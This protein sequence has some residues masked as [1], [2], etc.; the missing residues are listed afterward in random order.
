MLQV[1]QAYYHPAEKLRTHLRFRQ[2]L[3]G[4][5][6]QIAR[7]AKTLNSAGVGLSFSCF[8]PVFFSTRRFVQ[9]CTLNYCRDYYCRDYYCRDYYCRDCCCRDY[10]FYPLPQR[11]SPGF[12]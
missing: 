10:C 8:A 3:H 1:K 12:D 9:V 7:S 4:C 6:S 11:A 5:L 2:K